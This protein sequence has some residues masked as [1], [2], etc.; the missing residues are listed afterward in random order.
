ML[1][2]LLVHTA[3]N[4]QHGA[5]QSPG[6]H[7]A[8]K[9]AGPKSRIDVRKIETRNYGEELHSGPENRKMLENQRIISVHF[10]ELLLLYLNSFERSEKFFP[11][12]NFYLH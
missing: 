9:N 4:T 3:K 12:K 2:P 8:A 6:C 1:D 11:E 5:K 10:R 7:N